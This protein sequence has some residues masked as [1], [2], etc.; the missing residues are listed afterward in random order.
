M[1]CPSISKVP[2][3]GEVIKMLSARR[4]VSYWAISILAVC[5][6]KSCE[7]LTAIFEFDPLHAI[8]AC[9]LLFF[10]FAYDRSVV[11][12]STKS[13]D[14][15]EETGTDFRRDTGHFILTGL[16]LVSLGYAASL[17]NET[18]YTTVAANEQALKAVIHALLAYVTLAEIE[19]RRQLVSRILCVV[20]CVENNAD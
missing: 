10:T 20:F 14:S 4:Q 3:I 6:F 12:P 17:C 5:A 19:Y 8:T 9:M 2:P 18:W 13:K 11:S 16:A 1:G 15:Y 7:R